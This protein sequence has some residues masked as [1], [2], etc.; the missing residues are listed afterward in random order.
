MNRAADVVRHLRSKYQPEMCTVA[1][2]KMY[3]TIVTYDLFD[4]AKLQASTRVATA[5][6]CEAPG[7]RCCCTLVLRSGRELH[8]QTNTESFA[9][10]H[11][12]NMTLHLTLPG[13]FIC[14][15]NHYLKTQLSHIQWDWRALTL[16]PYHEGNDYKD[17]ISDDALIA[18]STRAL[19]LV[20]APQHEQ[21]K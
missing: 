9:Y 21:D 7:R 4:A 19:H 11:L 15:T 8:T 5:H 16:N 13:A 20:C 3:E 12:Y 14:A 2:A 10:V 17:M 1:W 6:L 18:V